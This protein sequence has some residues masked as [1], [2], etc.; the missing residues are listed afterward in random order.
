WRTG[1]ER[2]AEAH[3][4]WL[5]ARSYAQEVDAGAQDK[6]ASLAAEL[7][8]VRTETAEAC[9]ARDMAEGEVKRSNEC[10]IIAQEASAVL[11][12][13][14]EAARAARDAA[15]AESERLRGECG[16]ALK[17]ASVAK[18]EAEMLTEQLVELQTPVR[19]AHR[20]LDLSPEPSPLPSEIASA[21]EGSVGMSPKAAGVPANDAAAVT[22]TSDGALA[23]N[24]AESATDAQGG[25]VAAAEAGEAAEPPPKADQGTEQLPTPRTARVVELESDLI[26]VAQERDRAKSEAQDAAKA[27][28]DA[29]LSLA[30]L[31]PMLGRK[32]GVELGEK[33]A[34]STALSPDDRRQVV[35]KEAEAV[36]SA[37]ALNRLEQEHL[38]GD[39]LQ[40]CRR[41]AEKLTIIFSQVRSQ[42]HSD[43]IPE[44]SRDVDKYTVSYKQLQEEAGN[45]DHLQVIKEL[46]MGMVPVEGYEPLAPGVEEPIILQPPSKLAGAW[47]LPRKWE[48]QN[49]EEYLS[50]VYVDA[51]ITMDILKKL[52]SKVAAVAGREPSIPKTLKQPAR[53]IEKT[54]Q[55]YKGQYARLLD[56]ARA[57]IVCFTVAEIRQCVEALVQCIADG[58]IEVGR[59]FPRSARPECPFPRSARPESPSKFQALGSGSSL[60]Q[61]QATA[62]ATKGT[63]ARTVLRIKNRL[64]PA[65]EAEKQGGYRDIMLNLCFP[66]RAH[67]AARRHVCELQLHLALFYDIKKGGGHDLYKQARSLQLFGYSPEDLTDVANLLETVANGD[68][69]FLEELQGVNLFEERWKLC[70]LSAALVSSACTLTYLD[71]SG[72]KMMLGEAKVLARGLWGNATLVSLVMTDNPLDDDCLLALSN[73][74]NTATAVNEYFCDVFGTAVGTGSAMTAS[75]S[76]SH[77]LGQ[78]AKANLAKSTA[79]AAGGKGRL[80]LQASLQGK[81]GNVAGGML[82]LLGKVL[83][84]NV[85]VQVW[86]ALLQLI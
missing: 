17:E 12:A 47:S 49:R 37:L 16:A 8:A 41:R 27:K 5:L 44:I 4:W 64:D 10:T 40:E 45:E 30:V 29:E 62:A 18:A 74:F 28:K 53:A 1:S 48:E 11:K 26:R 58:Q 56:L 76:S 86:H 14:L 79:S 9:V 55:D 65:F 33:I 75:G 31:E 72:C 52:A 59:P 71:L 73:G 43:L 54:M 50:D 83:R 63:C 20:P 38:C 35:V 15:E 70:D 32:H 19:M 25:A 34:A 21:D 77:S 46:A 57:S 23:T 82:R 80:N 81:E 6:L 61:R 68:V 36:M 24:T 42:A 39:A 22:G 2:E 60:R 13:E 7:V 67:A 84:K 85:A 78:S 69:E 66:E 3:D 51:A